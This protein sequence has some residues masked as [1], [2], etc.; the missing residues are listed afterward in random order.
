MVGALP[1]SIFVYKFQIKLTLS[2][3]IDA[4]LAFLNHPV[5]RKDLEGNSKER[6]CHLPYW[7]IVVLIDW[8]RL[9]YSERFAAENI[10]K[11]LETENKQ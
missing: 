6:N 1:S 9:I 7:P 8:K 2:V 3:I 5:A 4:I 10:Y 11:Y